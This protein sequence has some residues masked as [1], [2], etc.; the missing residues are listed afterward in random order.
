MRLNAGN[1]SKFL[2]PW[3]KKN[4]INIFRE[5]NDFMIVKSSDESSE[6]TSSGEGSEFFLLVDEWYVPG[7]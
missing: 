7:Y 4:V 5:G 2:L 3:N 1:A 6:M